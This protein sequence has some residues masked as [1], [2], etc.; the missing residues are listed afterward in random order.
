MRQSKPRWWHRSLCPLLLPQT[1]QIQNYTWSDSFWDKSSYNL[2]ES[3]NLGNWENGH[4]YQVE[5]AKTRTLSINPTLGTVPYNWEATTSSQFLSEEPSA[6][7]LWLQAKGWVPKLPSSESQ[8]DLHSEDPQGYSRQI[9]LNR[10]TSTLYSCAPGAQCRRIRQKH[11]SLSISLE[12]VWLHTLQ[13]DT[14][15]SEF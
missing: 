6:Q 14:W 9:F 10:C 5:K 13:A 12:G 3:Y 11:P 7:F 8:H 15:R 1:H 2:R 4:L